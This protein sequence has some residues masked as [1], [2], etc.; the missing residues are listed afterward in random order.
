MPGL[1]TPLTIRDRTFPNRAWVS[2]MCQ[3]SAHDGV[4]GD[5]HLVHLGSLAAGRAGLIMSEA[6]AVVPEGRISPHCPGLWNDEQQQAWARIVDYVHGQNALFGFQ[7]AHAGRKASVAAPWEGGRFL[8]SADGGWLAMAP[9]AVAFA[10]MPEPLSMAVSDIE[11]TIDGF[12]ASAARALELGADVI[13]LHAAHGYLM[14]QFLSPLSNMRDDDFG[15]SLENRM[16]FPLLAVAAVR[17]VW[18]EDR[19]LFLRISMTDWA[20]GGWDLDQ[21][22]ELVDQ[23]QRA[24]VDLVDAS[25]A[26]LVADQMIPDVVTFQTDLAAELRRRTGVAV[27]AVGRITEPSQADELIQSGRADAVFLARQLLR[28]P[29]WPLRAAHELGQPIDWPLQYLRA[30]SWQ[31]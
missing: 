2:P 30:S 13:E 10:G 17:S 20:E 8:E 5:W 23:L 18:P 1:F 14:H 15:G 27:A 3:Y 7:L 16:R 25:S 4:V 24:G 22:V 11:R 19:P 12:A 28:D 6:T 9:S 21:S 29:H 31:S 26:G